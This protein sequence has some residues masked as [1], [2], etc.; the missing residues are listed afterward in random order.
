MILHHH[1]H[2]LHHPA[3]LLI[4]LLAG[5]ALL[6]HAD[7]SNGGMGPRSRSV[8]T[9][10]SPRA[11]P[12]RSIRCLFAVWIRDNHLANGCFQV[13]C[14]RLWGHRGDAQSH[15][16]REQHAQNASSRVQFLRILEQSWN[17]CGAIARWRPG[18]AGYRVSKGLWTRA[19]V[20]GL[21]VR[22]ADS[23]DWMSR[24]QCRYIV[25]VVPERNI[26]EPKGW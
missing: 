14:W 23:C 3:L 15:V 13:S 8:R 1:Y 6:S 2:R 5:V 4:T 26:K 17:L 12:L 18:E 24:C 9:E 10:A 16:Y 20:Q 25:R 11:V 22:A 21:S 7:T 19:A